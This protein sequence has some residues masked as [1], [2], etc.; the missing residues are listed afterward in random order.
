MT[1]LINAIAGSLRNSRYF[2][3]RA[4]FNDFTMVP[5]ADY[6]NTLKLAEQAKEVAGCVVECGVWKG[7]MA[8]GLAEVL[9]PARQYFLFDSFQGL[10]PAGQIDGTAAIK[11]QSNTKASTYYDN[12]SANASFAEKAMRMSCAKTYTLVPG[13]FDDTLAGFKLSEPIAFLHLDADWYQSTMVCLENL[14]DYLAPSAFVV[15]DDYH[16]WD[17]CSR[18]LHDFFSRRSAKERIKSLGNVC[19]FRKCATDKD[20]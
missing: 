12:C 14:F 6:V 13:W 16:T 19:Y 2:R 1:K 18:A 10:P 15:L 4:R 20:V 7:G 9:G 3:L 8:A 17:G 5:P 11:W